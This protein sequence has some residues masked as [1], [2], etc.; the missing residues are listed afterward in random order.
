MFNQNA[1]RVGDELLSER[2]ARKLLKRLPIICDSAR[3]IENAVWTRQLR[4]LAKNQARVAFERTRR[5]WK[6]LSLS[7]V[8]TIVVILLLAGSAR[9]K[10]L[11][12][13]L[14]CIST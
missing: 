3:Q 4:K 5:R 9:E 6:I 1:A 14:H 8:A 10:F 12:S 2:P 7:D 13:S 11:A